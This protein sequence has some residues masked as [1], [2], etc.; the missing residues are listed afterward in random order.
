MGREDV[1]PNSPNDQ[2]GTQLVWAANYGHEGVIELALNR[3]DV[4]PNRPD[5][6]DRTPLGCAAVA[7]HE[8]LSSCQAT[9][10]G[11]C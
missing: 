5:E 7:G 1:E 8:G 3:K 10:M 6:N 4:D 11:R 2:G 9:P